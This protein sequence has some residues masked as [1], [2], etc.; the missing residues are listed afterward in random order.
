M[1]EF[2]KW[3]AQ[4]NAIA[5]AFK[6]SQ[7]LFTAVEANIFPLLQDECSA[8][9]IA[10]QRDWSER[11]TAMLL[12]GLV[13]LGLVH[14][15]NGNY[16]NS[17]AA[18]ACL[19]PGREGYQGD[20]IRHTRNACETW[21]QLNQAVRT[22]TGVKTGS[23]RFDSEELRDFILGMSNIAFLSAPDMLQHIDLSPFRH[24]LD[25]G[26][27]PAT[28]PIAFLN[29]F[30]KLHATIFDLPPVIEIAREQV[31]KANLLHRCNF[32]PGDYYNDDLGTGYDLIL[33]SNVIHSMGPPDIQ[34]LFQNCFNALEPGGTLIVKDFLT[35]Q[36][37]SAPAY[38]LIFALH[39]LIHTEQGGTYSEADIAAWTQQAGFVNG[40][41]LPLTEKT[42]LWLVQKT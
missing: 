3:T 20:I 23:H 41:L 39:M 4:I 21:A 22:G 8:A 38:S 25:V 30:P 42:R 32:I 15:H 33:L 35:N 10:Q 2:H 31:H 18:A 29:A 11:G 1:T 37:H 14:K 17:P 28:Y 24:M 13:A 40:R 12:D 36:D 16:R 34:R 7:I 26:S 19:I 6:R 9:S 27:G 5:N